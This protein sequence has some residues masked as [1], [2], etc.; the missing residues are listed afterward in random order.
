MSQEEKNKTVHCQE[1]HPPSK[2]DIEGDH[3]RCGKCG[4]NYRLDREAS[5]WWPE[6]WWSIK[7]EHE[8]QLKERGNE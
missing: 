2:Y 3:W 6:Q 1:C 4:T 8:K 7:E 5:T